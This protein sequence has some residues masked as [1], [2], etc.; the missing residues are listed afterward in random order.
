MYVDDGE[1]LSRVA[2]VNLNEYN[3]T[4][5]NPGTRETREVRIG[6]EGMEGKEVRVRR[7]T[8]AGSDATEG[9][10]F[11]GWKYEFEDGGMAVKEL[12]VKETVLVEGGVVRVEIDDSSAL[13]LDFE[14]D[15]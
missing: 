11:D 8:A 4:V 9:V 13:M 12:A 6:V 15:E 1:T 2:V 5:E 14:G 3:G 10:R 7:L